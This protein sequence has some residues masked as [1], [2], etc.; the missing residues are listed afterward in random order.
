MFVIRERVFAQPVY[1]SEH[2]HRFFHYIPL[3]NWMEC[4][5]C[6]PRNV[7][8]VKVAFLSN[9]NDETL[10]Q[11]E[12]TNQNPVDSFECHS[13]GPLESEREY[14]IDRALGISVVLTVI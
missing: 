10:R 3:S 11:Y 12:G 9:N 14:M 13:E 6:S 7:L 8:E 1:C 4:V 2:T 5:Y